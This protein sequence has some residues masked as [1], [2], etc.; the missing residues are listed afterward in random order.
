MDLKGYQDRHGDLVSA[1]RGSNDA[2]GIWGERTSMEPLA[3]EV[4]EGMPAGWLER[5][6]GEET[7]RQA[8][9]FFFFLSLRCKFVVY[10]FPRLHF[11]VLVGTAL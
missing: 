9:F 4:I 1:E 6:F 7:A 11:F 3:D 10:F 5:Q 8:S 2:G